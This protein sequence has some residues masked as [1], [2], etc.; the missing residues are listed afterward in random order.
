M[1]AQQLRQLTEGY[2]PLWWVFAID[3][4]D[5]KIQLSIYRRGAVEWTPI[6]RLSKVLP[7]HINVITDL[8]SEARRLY[9]NSHSFPINPN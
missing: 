2:Q 9:E 4:P 7:S 8:L 6:A 3:D 1:T 5:E